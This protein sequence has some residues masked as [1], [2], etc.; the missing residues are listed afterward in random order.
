MERDAQGRR[1][2][3]QAW[4][5]WGATLAGILA[6]DGWLL[7]S[8]RPSLSDGAGRHPIMATAGL[9]YLF[10]HFRRWPRFLG[11]LD[12]LSMAARLISS[13]R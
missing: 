9:T 6:F 11:S 3:E 2:L 13:H 7:A 4:Q 8:G 10:C 1:T 12:P 5:A